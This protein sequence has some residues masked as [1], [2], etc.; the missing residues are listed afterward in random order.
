MYTRLSPEN[1]NYK[2]G[3]YV[4]P[5]D[6]VDFLRLKTAA[7]LKCADVCDI[8]RR[9]LSYSKEEN[10]CE[11]EKIGAMQISTLEI[12]CYLEYFK[13]T[14]LLEYNGLLVF[15]ATVVLKDGSLNHV[16]W[17]LGDKELFVVTCEAL[18]FNGISRD[19]EEKLFI[20]D[21]AEEVIDWGKPYVKR[22]SLYRVY[23]PKRRKFFSGKYKSIKVLRDEILY[24]G[25]YKDNP[26]NLC[27]Y[28]T[29]RKD[30][31]WLERHQ[32]EVK[33]L[34]NVMLS[35]GIP[36]VM[37]PSCGGFIDDCHC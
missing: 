3:F 27:I 25:W 8:V 11:A 5:L 20:G 13:Q 28:K 16:I 12:Y 30:P 24:Q 2:L 4:E 18:S 22:T 29:E 33:F 21:K 19:F 6:P 36:V 34:S 15:H 7:I 14:K 26:K 23:V 9:T 1:S 32:D 37:S 35:S 10:L 17:P 31:M